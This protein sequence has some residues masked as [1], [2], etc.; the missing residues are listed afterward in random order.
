VLHRELVRAHGG[1]V[2]LRDKGLLLSA[3]AAPEQTFLYAPEADI[4]DL[5]AAYCFHLV[6][7]H[8]FPPL[9]D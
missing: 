2:G 8:P 6:K 4:F 1:V 7:N 9:H 5:A 3:L